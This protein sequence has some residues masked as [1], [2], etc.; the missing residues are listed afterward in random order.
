MADCFIVELSK[1]YIELTLFK[2]L[3]LKK[4]S[5]DLLIIMCLEVLDSKQ[6]KFRNFILDCSSFKGRIDLLYIP[7]YLDCISIDF[8]IYPWEIL[9]NYNK[10]LLRYPQTCFASVKKGINWAFWKSESFIKIF[11]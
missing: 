2:L 8:A 9:L 4:F 6:Y 5:K 3:S 7:C 1:S 11:V 10:L